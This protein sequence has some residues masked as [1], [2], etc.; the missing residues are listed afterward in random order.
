MTTLPAAPA[1][2]RVS[3]LPRSSA[4]PGTRRA[5]SSALR[6]A[7]AVKKAASYEVVREEADKQLYDAEQ[8][9]KELGA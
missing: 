2:P 7:A 9:L 8:K 3:V 6:G 1:K 5:M 4:K